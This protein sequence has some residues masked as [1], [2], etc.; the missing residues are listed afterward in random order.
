MQVALLEHFTGLCGRC[1]EI[2]N[3]SFSA[4]NKMLLIRAGIHKTL[5]R[6]ANREDPDHTASEKAV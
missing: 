2:W 6:I 3:V 5:V 4:L 1:S